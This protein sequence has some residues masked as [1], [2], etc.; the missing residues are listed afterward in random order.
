MITMI[1]RATGSTKTTETTETTAGARAA[2]RTPIAGAERQAGGMPR[3][4]VSSRA[5]IGQ[6]PTR[7]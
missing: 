3:P 7:P 4:G 2:D 1:T 5:V 6:A